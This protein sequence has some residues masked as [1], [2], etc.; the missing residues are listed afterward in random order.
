MGSLTAC[1][2]KAGTSLRAEDKSAIL[3]LSRQ[4]RSEGLS[5]NDAAMKAIDTQL[6]AVGKMIEQEQAPKKVDLFGEAPNA[7][8]QAAEDLRQK[9]KKKEQAQRDRAPT[10]NDF[11]LGM[12]DQKTGDE[13]APGQAEIAVNEDEAKAKADLMNALADLGSL[14]SAPGRMNIAPE[15]EQKLLPILT[16]LFDAAFRLGYTKFKDA[17]KFALDQI[18]AALGQETANSIDLNH[19]QGAYIAMSGGKTGADNIRT[20][21]TIE[22][23]SEVENHT[24]QTDNQRKEQL[25]VPSANAS[26]ERH[27][28]QPATEPA[29]GQAVSDE[30][31]ATG[32][33]PSQAG[34]RTD[35][36]AG[37]G[38]LDG[39]GLSSGGAA[40][41]RE[42]GDQRVHRRDG[43]LELASITSGDQFGERGSDVG[44]RGIPPEPIST[45]QVRETAESFDDR[46]IKG[47]EQK[48]AASIKPIDGDLQNIRDTLPQ[49]L[50]AQ[51]DDV[52]K[53][54]TRFA[55]P[56]GFG[57]LFTNGTGT[58]KTFSG[59]G[60]IKRFELKGKKN[61][62]ILAPDDKIAAD[63]IKAGKLLG[64]DITKLADTKDSGKG[65]VITTYANFG[66]NDKT[67]SRQWDLVVADEAHSLMQEAHGTPTGYL[68]NLRAITYHPDGVHTRHSMLH[69]EEIER[70]AFLHRE[71]KANNKIM[72]NDDTMDAMV[73]SLRSENEKLEAEVSKIDAKLR[74][75]LDALKDEVHN[76]QSTRPRLVALSATPFAY[77]KTID[78]ANGYLF[79]YNDGQPSEEREFRGYN[80]GSNRD[81]YFMQ[82]FGY[83]MRYNKLT[84]PDGSKVDRGLLQRNWNANLKKAGSLSGRMLDVVPDYD[85]RFVTVDSAIGHRIDEALEWISKQRQDAPKGDEG[86]S[87]LS[88]VINDKFK[89]LQKRYLLE[90]IKAT[91]VI[92]IVKQHLALNRKVVVFHDYKKGGGFNPF[93]ISIGTAKSEEPNQQ[94]RI[95]SFR[96][97]VTAFNTEFKDLVEAPLGDMDSPIEVFARELPQTMFINGDEK[98]S[99]LLQRYE[100]FQDDASGPQVML[101]QSAKNKGWSGHDTTGKHQRVLINLGQ[102]TAPTLAI[103]QEGRIYRTGQASDA[104]MRYLNTGTNWER[105]TFASTIAGRASTA[106]NLG[107]GEMARA[108]KDSFIQSF[109][110]SDAYPPGHEGEGKGGKERDKAANDALT[111]YD[112]AKTYYWA[113]QKKNSKTKAQEGADYFA[114][115]EPVGLK[116]VE[117]LD[118]RPEE[119]T[120]E[121]S[122]GHGAISRWLPDVTK[123][124]V[125]E[126]SLALRSRLALVMNPNEDRII[127]GT[128]EELGVNNKYDGIVMNPP[129]GSGGKTA[130]DHLAKAATHLRDG[131]RIV[132]LI[133]TGPAADKKFEKWFYEESERKA[134]PLYVDPNHGPIYK[135]DTL[136]LTGF[137]TLKKIVVDKVDGSGAAKYVRDA[138]TPP[139]GAINITAINKVDP[140]GKRTEQVKMAEGLS[141]VADIKLPQVTFER[142][143]T[144]VATRIVVIEK[145]NEWNTGGVYNRDFT[146][147]TTVAD[148]FDSL[149]HMAL[150]D[151][152]KKEAASEVKAE[153]SKP[154]PKPEAPSVKLGDMVTLMGKKYEVTTYTTN[155][156]KELKGAWVPT[157]AVALY[158]GARST[159]Q[160][161][162]K[163]FFVRE[164]DFPKDADSIDSPMMA[165][166]GQT[167]EPFY[168]ALSKGIEGIKSNS[169]PG[170]GWLD[171]I[172]G[173]VNKGQVKADEVEWSGV[174]D[175]LKLQTGK[176]SK[177]QVLEYLAANGVQIK[178][179]TLGEVDEGLLEAFLGDEAGE[180]FTREEAIEVLKGEEGATPTKYDR[181]QLPGGTNYREVLLTLP[182]QG[183]KFDPSKV[184]VKRIRQSVTQGSVQ[185]YY[186]GEKIGR[187]YADEGTPKTNYMRPESEWVDTAKR[188]FESGETLP[189]GRVVSKGKTGAYKSSHWDQPNVLAHIRVNDR[190]DAEGKRVLFVEEI[191]SD[192]G[193]DGKKTGFR[194]K[195]DVAGIESRTQAITARLREIAKTVEGNPALEEEW[196]RLSDEKSKLTDSLVRS[197]DGAPVAPFVQ[198]TEGWLNLALKRIIKIAVDE[199]YDKVAFINGDQSAERYDLSKHIKEFRYEPIKGTD[200]YEIGAVD[201]NGQNVLDEDEVTLARIEELVGKEIASKV[202]R[203]EGAKDKDGYRDWHYLRGLDL[204]VGGT[205]MKAFYDQIVPSVAK[206]VLKKVGGGAL[207]TVQIGSKESGKWG[208]YDATDEDN[209]GLIESFPSKAQAEEFA[210]EQDG[211]VEVRQVPEYGAQTGFTI[212]PAMRDKAANGLPMFNRGQN[213]LLT[214]YDREEAL[215]K[216]QS[217]ADALKQE[218]KPASKPRQPVYTADQID[219]F[220]PQSSL[221][222]KG[223]QMDEE[224]FRKAFGSSGPVQMTVDQ[225]Q[226][227]TNSLTKDWTNGPKIV[228]VNST[229]DLPVK[230]PADARGL[231]WRGTVYLVASAHASTGMLARTL[232]HESVAHY[233]LRK[234]LGD[235]GW[236]KLMTN[237][238]LAL[239]SG[240]KPLNAIRAE[241]RKAYADKDG[242]FRLGKN[243]EADE[244][245]ARAVENAIDAATGEF[246]PG[247]SFLKEAYAKIAQFLRDH[248]IPVKFTNLELQGMLVASSKWLKEGSPTQVANGA[249][250]PAYALGE[251]TKSNNVSGVLSDRELADLHSRIM[252]TPEIEVTTSGLLAD[253]SYKE[254]RKNSVESYTGPQVIVNYETGESIKIAKSGIENALQHGMNLEK[255]AVVRVLDKLIENAALV[256]RDTKNMK[257][258]VKSIETFASRVSVDGK[259]YVARIVVREL[260]D[261]R[262][263]Y[264]HEL[265]NLESERLAGN[266]GGSIES[267]SDRHSEPQPTASLGRIVLQQALEV[268]NGT[269]AR[270]APTGELRPST[271][272]LDTILRVFGGNLAARITSPAYGWLARTLD[273]ITPE[274][275][276]AGLVSDYGLRNEYLDRKQEMKTAQRQHARHLGDVI[277]GLQ[278]LDR[279]QSRVAYFWMQEHPSH[280]AE[281]KL[282]EQLPQESRATLE[283]LKDQIDK[284]GQE[285]VKLGLITAETIDRNRFAYLHRSYKRYEME[286]GSSVKGARSRAIKILGDQFKGRGLR[287]DADM[288]KIAALDWYKR[289]TQEGKADVSLKGIM[290]HRLERRSTPDLSTP[291]MIG[292]ASRKLGKLREIKYWP[293]SEPI[294]L[295]LSDWRNDGQWEARFFDK[296][297]KVG[298]WRDFTLEERTA[299]GEIQE[300]RYGVAKTIMQMS[301][302]VETARF[303]DWIAR[304]EAVGHESML[305]EDAIALESAST[306][307]GR[308]YKT[309]EWV[310][311]PASAIPGTAGLKRFGNLAGRWVP[312]PVWN[313]LRQIATI[314][315]QDVISKVYGPMLRAW[316]I[317]KT[318]LSPATHMNN[319]MANFVMADAH[320]IQAKHMLTALRTYRSYKT[321]EVGKE[322]M[323]AF[324]DNGGDAGMFNTEE[325]KSEIFEPLLKQLE[326]DL[327]SNAN[328][329]TR[330]MMATHVIGLLKAKEFRQAFA[331]I[332]ETKTAKQAG[333]PFKKLIKLYGQEDEMFRLAAFIKA[334]ED[335]LSDHDAGKFARESFLNYEIN[336]PWIAALRKSAMPFIAFTYRAAPMMAK[337]ASERP[338]KL[339]KWMMVAGA[340]NALG[341]LMSGGDED[342]ERAFMPDEKSG[343]V[344]G[345]VPKLIR[346]PWNDTNKQ[347]VFLDIRRWIPVGD[348]VDTGQSHAAVP[349]PPPLMPGGPVVILG[350]LI[351]NTS[352]FT[353]Q[354]ITKATDTLSEKWGKAVGYLWKAAMPNML[355][356]PGTYASDA[357]MNAGSGKTDTFGREQSLPMAVSSSFGVKLASYP[358]DVLIQNEARKLSAEIGE[359]RRGLRS[360]SR[361]LARKGIDQEDMDKKTA[362]MQEKIKERTDEFNK[363]KKAAG[364]VQD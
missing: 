38:Q 252:A 243:Q 299:M 224:A 303:L 182:V 103:Q 284:L 308:A 325:I 5:P 268:N 240:N 248:G 276:K 75:D 64:L 21:S 67:A 210:K 72:S 216:Q 110:E 25:N 206:D 207:E 142:A 134:A 196:N 51:Q 132:A 358:Q 279:Q 181:Y 94:A 124:T 16:R 14:L 311:V 306:S 220:N 193:Q 293:V 73:S 286:D 95:E 336:A 39:V 146:G 138:N 57:M 1:L 316:K 188:L 71:I 244:V 114:T 13:V 31:R 56:N 198:K 329:T 119:D 52:H 49:L 246:R 292:D 23:K 272:P 102:P 112:R 319:V 261:G 217:E 209:Q 173:L 356:L 89:Y 120:L 204:K 61:A 4:Y 44:I 267:F 166:G 323:D 121:P 287:D 273:A 361:Q 327:N 8:Q 111:E 50:P 98:K 314:N 355:G 254:L 203:K 330:L 107:M 222:A 344:W 231:Y 169:A 176:V 362:T 184:V 218:N 250:V 156:G 364:M 331:M 337:V 86:F 147:I 140:T 128:F 45:K 153:P 264:D 228:V 171:A 130:I 281:A 211:G 320:D 9:Q 175:W 37:S 239:A 154:E 53:A 155:A 253:G 312:G 249:A 168:S 172:K 131:G 150:P 345:I 70:S 18:K 290:F 285:A 7:S 91:E 346:M 213:D 99:D 289:K 17:A 237:V 341:Y 338:W 59:L 233:G 152:A 208:V 348:M 164:R 77:E 215:K 334:R 136:T 363:K 79:E 307:L 151:R 275:L 187:Q 347:P 333:V 266:S 305:P 197:N 349:V 301:R 26:V 223:L 300:V 190:T 339:A 93:S 116:M 351:A 310:Q 3:A 69:R 221:F 101:V 105:W 65:I 163:G 247:Y 68:H 118:A 82:H 185:I 315:D 145:S 157:K 354:N 80:S 165:R 189:D 34:G 133:P 235:A 297:G 195:L 304:N 234:M 214:N 174:G 322:L 158:N 54:E 357:V 186:D 11:D 283:A 46:I 143:G 350:E 298:M 212:T 200:K 35:R 274:T 242:V 241:V 123:R 340:L 170:L 10:A 6:S 270:S 30:L 28:P 201:I 104:I 258:G 236:Y 324:L 135:G 125:V 83:T 160:V 159:F 194:Q 87:M 288:A 328:K 227:I 192:W 88:E 32:G 342:K 81:R 260:A 162:G 117:W 84:E 43:E 92:P 42:R 144:G 33:E 295:H 78:W 141:L 113:T 47:R 326:D 225:V 85:R 302:D 127:A 36:G 40:T 343:R 259:P 265:S 41:A 256:V 106:E 219:L 167:S 277:D 291:D 313:D 255:R 278:N 230:S 318:A 126:P 245:A 263:F 22:S 76:R 229:A 177:A 62:I 122:A 48:A 60:I 251:K 15:Q 178:E 309:N 317:S 232:A 335:G 271:A 238:Q 129:F 180:G 12:V 63:W 109:D 332:G 183:P 149:E 139:N 97:A 96:K 58:G 29:V 359:L 100:K 262:R 161:K 55:K 2:K 66:A 148:L 205:G 296:S 257:Q 74:A 19:L 353:G 269:F 137:G 360:D 280:E 352:L 108:L 202:E 24:A 115:P 321:N 191:Q 27:S 294:P 90:A 282:M 226:R 20:V 199:G 179:V